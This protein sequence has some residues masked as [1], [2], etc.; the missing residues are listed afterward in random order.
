MIIAKS[1]ATNLTSQIDLIT[2]TVNQFAQ[3]PALIKAIK[4]HAAMV[5]KQKN[6]RMEQFMQEFH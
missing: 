4:K 2:M 1:V 6:S 5:K 3:D